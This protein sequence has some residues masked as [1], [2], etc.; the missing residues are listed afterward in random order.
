LGIGPLAL[1]HW[2]WATGIGQIR[3]PF[4]LWWFTVK[5]DGNPVALVGV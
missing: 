2:H 3:D 4:A 5:I 1:G